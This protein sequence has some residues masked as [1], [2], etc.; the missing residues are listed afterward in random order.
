MHNG[1]SHEIYCFSKNPVNATADLVSLLIRTVGAHRKEAAVKVQK[2]MSTQRVFILQ[3]SVLFLSNRT[4]MDSSQ[5]A[6][7]E[8]SSDKS[9][10]ATRF[11]RIAQFETFVSNVT[12]YWSEKAILYSSNDDDLQ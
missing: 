3:H 1:R 9:I 5:W 10:L 2:H 4:K 12:R 11:R 8:S 7:V 6:V